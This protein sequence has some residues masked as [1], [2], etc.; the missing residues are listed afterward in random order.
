MSS[1]DAPPAARS[2]SPLADYDLVEAKKPADPQECD[3][4]G[5]LTPMKVFKKPRLVEQTVLQQNV[6]DTV[7]KVLVQMVMG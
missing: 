1:A 6:H 4:S 5:F 3:D 2:E 7:V